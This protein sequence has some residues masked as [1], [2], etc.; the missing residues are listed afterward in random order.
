MPSTQVSQ[1]LKQAIVSPLLKSPNLDVNI[2]YNYRPISQLPFL[3][4]I[5]EKVIAVQI[6][7]HLRRFRNPLCPSL[8]FCDKLLE[9]L[10]KRKKGQHI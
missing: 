1:E 10:K 7:E 2:F 6:N 5:L 4:K 3:S 9:T 8:A